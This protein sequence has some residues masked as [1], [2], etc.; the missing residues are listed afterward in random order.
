MGRSF[1]F[2]TAEAKRIESALKAALKLVCK[3]GASP[4]VTLLIV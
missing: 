1:W 2:I 4:N 3:D